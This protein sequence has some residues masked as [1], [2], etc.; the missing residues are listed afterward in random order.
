MTKAVCAGSFDPVTLGHVDVIE[1]AG[2]MFDSLIVCV[3]HNVRKSGYFSIEERCHFLSE[4]TK[5]ISNVRIDVFSG[6]LTDY[7]KSQSA[8]VIVRGLRS[9]TDF[10]YEEAQTG[11]LR[12]LDPR[13]DTVFLLT[14]PQL[15]FI[16]SSG[17]RELIE[18]QG[19][20]H[21]LVPEAV[22][23]AINKIYEN[24]PLGKE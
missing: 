2:R 6:L 20:V 24:Q 18:F 13:L 9:L 23:L 7:M 12:H 3:F 5:H 1:R 10:D 17:V 4:A 16:S 8:T 22:E 11:T 19:S 14:S 15:S 21:G